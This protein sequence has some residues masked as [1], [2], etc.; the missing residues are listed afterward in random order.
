MDIVRK[1]KNYMSIGKA[2]SVHIVPM[3]THNKPEINNIFASLYQA[4]NNLENRVA[5]LE[6][7]QKNKNENENE[8]ENLKN[9]KCN[10]CNAVKIDVII[11]HKSA[12]KLAMKS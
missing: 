11:E 8:N 6:S 10:M 5:F 9:T 4:I 3:Y 2:R 7:D 12:A 1:L